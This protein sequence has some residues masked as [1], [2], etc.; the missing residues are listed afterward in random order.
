M[1][2]VELIA[3]ARRGN[4]SW[5][6][7][8]ALATSMV[9]GLPGQWVVGVDVAQDPETALA[10]VQH[11]AQA[12]LLPVKF[13]AASLVFQRYCHRY[14]ALASYL[15]LMEGAAPLL[16]AATCQTR[17]LSGSPA[18]IV[19]KSAVS[20]SADEVLGALL[21]EHLL[22]FAQQL[23]QVAGL[24][25]PN[26][27]GNIAAAF[28]MGVR[29][30]S[31]QRDPEAVL[32]QANELVA[33]RPELSRGGTFRLV[34]KADVTRVFYDRTSCCHWHTVHDGERCSWCSLRSTDERTQR[35][36]ALLG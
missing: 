17:F 2:L 5:A 35:F 16:S 32:D 6:T 19:V 12:R 36:E 23:G 22:P 15:L 9:A 30:A 14:A 21:E 29:F 28:A 11:H 8:E 31:A 18:G 25:W 13:A 4:P 34:S 27:W 7:E 33:R 3:S 1:T 10:L 20:N 26:A 24:S